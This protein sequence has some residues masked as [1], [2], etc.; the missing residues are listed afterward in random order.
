M[1]PL[2]A[3]THLSHAPIS[4]DV[5]LAPSSTSIV[6]RRTRTP[7]PPHTLSQPA[8]DPPSAKSV[9]RCD[10]LP[11]PVIFHAASTITNLDL[12]RA[13]HSAL[14]MQ[15]TQ[16][17]WDALGHGT[18]AQLKATR[19]YETRC[20]AAGLG[21]GAWEGGIRRI[22]W[23]GEKTCLVGIEVDRSSVES[24]VGKLIFARP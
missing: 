19:A 22:D 23:L 2:L 16:E 1:H 5:R 17:E 8:T 18:H 12:L 24:G 13:V 9:L 20:A 10:K 14:S 15:V 6:D 11:W 7:I 3:S 21:T 4:Y